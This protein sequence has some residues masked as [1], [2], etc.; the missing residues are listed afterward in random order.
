MFR[1]AGLKS[2]GSR[3]AGR[4]SSGQIAGS[5]PVV[6]RPTRDEN[7][8]GVIVGFALRGDGF[9]R[10]SRT[11]QIGE[12]LCTGAPM[13]PG[14]RGPRP[15]SHLG[16]QRIVAGAFKDVGES[17]RSVSVILPTGNEITGDC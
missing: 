16:T 9:A 7:L 1:I 17:P 15:C 14:M 13:A 4:F 8:Q 10:T 3:R 11:R 12:V 2:L 6:G 5:L